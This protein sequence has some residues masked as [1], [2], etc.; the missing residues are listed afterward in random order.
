M[1]IHISIWLQQNCNLL[2]KKILSKTF[3]SREE[4]QAEGHKASK[5]RFTLVPTVDTTG[6][7][8]PKASAN[9]L[10]KSEGI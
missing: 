6:D 4:K 1:A 9:A 2:E 3:I 5:E 8:W 10:G 7:S